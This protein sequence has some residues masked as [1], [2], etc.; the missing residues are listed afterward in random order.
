MSATNARPQASIGTA[1]LRAGILLS[2]FLALVPT[3][4]AQT[5]R[6]PSLS[7]GEIDQIRDARLNPS[8]CIV[9]YVKFLDERT[10]KIQDLYAK[11]RQP[12]REED[13]HDLLVQFTSIADELA[14]NLDDY[15]PRHADL[16]KALP[17]VLE[18]TDRWATALKSPPDHDAYSVAR[19]IA[20][21][22][23]RDLRESSTEL[24]AEQ[25]TW[26][27]AH[28]P[29]KQKPQQQGAPPIDIPR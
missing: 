21:E 5:S 26:F 11:P 24:A 4:H 15:G 23:V 2:L 8:D 10:K 17:K 28:P 27:K 19:K 12:G 22:S 9:L 13:T 3:L 18:A 20:L 16:R 14:D 7:E 25:T 29:S 6:P 1:L